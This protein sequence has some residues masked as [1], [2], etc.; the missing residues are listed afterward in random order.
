MFSPKV[1]FLFLVPHNISK[2]QSFGPPSSTPGVERD[3]RP[4][5]FS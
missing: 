1:N 5:S 3:M 2:T 4:L